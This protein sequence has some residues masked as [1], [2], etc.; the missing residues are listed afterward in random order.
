MSGLE[1]QAELARAR[2]DIPII[3]ISGHADIP[4][5]VLA[6]KAGAVE[7]LTK[8]FREQELLE[9]IQRGIKRHRQ[10]RE[11]RFKLAGC[12]AALKSQN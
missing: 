10:M 4:M 7:F 9:A 8:P 2:V 6:M 11:E 1:L 3:F 5:S 12:H